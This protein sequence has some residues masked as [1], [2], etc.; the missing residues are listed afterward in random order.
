[1]KS[2]STTISATRKHVYFYMLLILGAIAVGNLKGM[3]EQLAPVQTGGASQVDE[4][5]QMVQELY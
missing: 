4:V 2:H 5:K 3:R 1:M